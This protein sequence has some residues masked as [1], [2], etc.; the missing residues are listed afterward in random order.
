MNVITHFLASRFSQQLT[1]GGSI[2]LLCAIGACGKQEQGQTAGQKLDVAIEK[3]EQAATEAKAKTETLAAK[4]GESLK[5]EVEKAKAVGKTM[6]E[7]ATVTVEDSVITASVLAEF[8]RDPELSAT[9]TK[10]VTQNGL[11]T[12]N[13]S[14]PSEIAKEKASVLAKSI[15]GVASV[16]NK[17]IVKSTMTN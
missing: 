8:A 10:V 1:L 17:L 6:A 16:D 9:K 4:S 3:T 5:V 2:V 7:S 12:L 15:K 11:V 13:G 14:S